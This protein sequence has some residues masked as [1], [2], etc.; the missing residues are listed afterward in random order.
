[1]I[2]LRHVVEV[3]LLNNQVVSMPNTSLSMA[4]F[5]PIQVHSTLFTAYPN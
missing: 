3:L 2:Q 4:L 1:M 5:S